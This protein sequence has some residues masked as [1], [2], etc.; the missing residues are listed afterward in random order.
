[1]MIVTMK[2]MI[3]TMLKKISVM[4]VN[5]MKKATVM[6]TSIRLQNQCTIFLTE[7]IAGHESSAL[8]RLTLCQA[9]NGSF[10][11]DK[12]V[13][14]ALGVDAVQLAEGGSRWATALALAFLELNCAGERELW[15]LVAE[16]AVVWL[17]AGG[18]AEPEIETARQF[19]VGLKK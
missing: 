14:A 11:A 2:W 18:E 1:M 7:N 3:V 12:A 16:K 6:V 10:P 15:S 8:L 19:L 9:A 17:Q 5:R 13:A 4:T